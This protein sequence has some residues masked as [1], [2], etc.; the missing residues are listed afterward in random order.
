MRSIIVVYPA[1]ISRKLTLGIVRV[2]VLRSGKVTRFRGNTHDSSPVSYII[3]IITVVSFV[4]II[5][6]TKPQRF[7]ESVVLVNGK[8]IEWRWCTLFRGRYEVLYTRIILY[9]VHDNIYLFTFVHDHAHKQYLQ[10]NMCVCAR[11]CMVYATVRIFYFMFP[12]FLFSFAF[13]LTGGVWEL[14][15][16]QISI[17]ERTQRTARAVSYPFIICA[18]IQLAC[19]ILL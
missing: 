9:A 5:R 16:V 11:V 10:T 8:R 1:T 7:V 3:I 12:L 19:V 2:R 18:Y 4:M 6:T 14:W 13:F 17:I 15:A